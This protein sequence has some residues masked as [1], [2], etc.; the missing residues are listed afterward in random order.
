MAESRSPKKSKKIKNHGASP[1]WWDDPVLPISPEAARPARG[2]MRGAQGVLRESGFGPGRFRIGSETSHPGEPYRRGS[3]RRP[4]IRRPRAG[5]LR[6]RMRRTGPEPAD[7][8]R[9]PRGG[10][11]PWVGWSGRV[12][13]RARGLGRVWPAFLAKQ[14]SILISLPKR[15]KRYLYWAMDLRWWLGVIFGTGATFVGAVAKISWKHAHNLTEL[16][17]KRKSRLYAAIGVIFLA[18]NPP[19]NLAGL[20]LAPQTVIAA[21]A[22]SSPAFNLMMAPCALGESWTRW[23]VLSAALVC[24]G[25]TGVGAFGAKDSPTYTYDELIS[26]YSRP[27]YGGRER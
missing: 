12:E 3:D 1:P 8:F 9:H 11:I 6:M 18:L 10:S 20:A 22:G 26:F 19:L 16:G 25:C 7:A 5:T 13:V 17:D 15:F 21:T 2:A 4:A 24:V 23:D 14:S 27:D